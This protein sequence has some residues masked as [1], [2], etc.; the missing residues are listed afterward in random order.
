MV[1][2]LEITK[3]LHVGAVVQCM[4]FHPGG[5]ILVDLFSGTPDSGYQVGT[6]NRKSSNTFIY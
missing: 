5:A 2:K 3:K 1:F 4:V 6:T